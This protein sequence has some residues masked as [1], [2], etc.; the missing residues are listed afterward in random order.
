MVYNAFSQ[1]VSDYQEH[2]GAVNTATSPSVGYTYADG[3]AGTIRRTGVVYPNARVIGY[4]Y[5]AGA[6]DAFNRVTAIVDGDSASAPPLVQYARLGSGAF[7]QVDY[8]EPLLRYDLAFGLGDDPYTGLDQFDR[9]VD[10]RWWNTASGQDV[11]RVQHGYDLAGNRLWRRNPVAASLGVEMDELYAYDNMSQLTAF[12]RGLLTSDQTALVDGTESFAQAWSLDPTGN[13]SEFQEDSDGSGT[14]DLDQPRT[15]NAANEITAFGDIAGPQWAA[16]T[17]GMAGN[18]TALPQPASPTDSLCCTYDAWNRLVS[19]AAA[20]S[21]QPVAR[22]QYDGRGYR[23][24]AETFKSGSLSD[25]RNFYYSDQWQVVEER[26][27]QATADRQ[28][29][30]G[31]RYVDDLV[32]RDR[33]T[34]GDGIRDER[35]FGLQDP[36]WNV[37][38]LS[39]LNGAAVERYQYSAYGEPTFLTEAFAAGT[40]SS[41]EVETLYCGYRCHVALGLYLARNRALWPH[42]GRW[43]RRDPIGYSSHDVSLYRYVTGNPAGLVDPSGLQDYSVSTETNGCT[44]TIYA[45]HNFED[46]GAIKSDFPQI[47]SGGNTVVPPN[48]FIIAIGCGVTGPNGKRCSWTSICKRTT[49]ITR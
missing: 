14:W 47:D 18:M 25:S 37:T 41:Y 3:S 20:T 9:I 29:V 4:N 7:V 10:L 30:W 16:P 43:N 22:Y 19:V 34:T 26:A 28:F 32:L 38:G 6:D 45:G 46:I 27:G 11:E 48:Q 39:D 23:T 17:Y 21:G 8:P 44:I 33:D 24:V 31:Q 5:A 13:W 42:L 12:A 1:L 15:H 36:N 40:A 49:R 2:E 35:L